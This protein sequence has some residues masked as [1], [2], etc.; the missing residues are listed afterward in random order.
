MTLKSI[1]LER[2][3]PENVSGVVGLAAIFGCQC[4]EEREMEANT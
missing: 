4:S 1:I 2:D 3:W